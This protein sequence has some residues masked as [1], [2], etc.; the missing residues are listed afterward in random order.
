MRL[1]ADGAIS[2]HLDRTGVARRDG[3]E[4]APQQGVHRL[5]HR[6]VCRVEG[7]PDRVP[8]LRIRECVEL[9]EPIVR[10]SASEVATP[11]LGAVAAETHQRRLGTQ[12]VPDVG[13][14]TA[15]DVHHTR[16]DHQLDTVP[17]EV[18]HDLHEVL[19]AQP[20]PVCVV[21][22]KRRQQT[23]LVDVDVGHTPARVAEAPVECPA[24]GRLPD[25]RRTR[26]PQDPTLRRH[27]DSPDDRGRAVPRMF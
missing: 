24:D 13:P 22:R 27:D 19:R 15:F 7:M 17:A 23:E 4:E 9:S 10:G 11:Q 6:H 2:G 25:P 21:R 8:V 3:V 14:G 1:H 5:V 20:M 16:H 26:Q 18:R 12:A